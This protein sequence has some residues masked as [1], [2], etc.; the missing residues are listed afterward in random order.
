MVIRHFK[1]PYT[2]K[3]E[4]GEISMKI[5]DNEKVLV[6]EEPV[7]AGSNEIVVI[8]KNLADYNE[9]QKEVAKSTLFASEQ[10]RKG[11]LVLKY[12]SE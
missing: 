6:K 10:E 7:G 4:G 1:V 2:L 11:F 3:R 5:D 9:S 12:L 8:S